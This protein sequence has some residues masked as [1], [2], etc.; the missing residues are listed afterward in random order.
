MIAN[1][2]R[3]WSLLHRAAPWLANKDRTM[4]WSKKAELVAEWRQAFNILAREARVPHLEMAEVIIVHYRSRGR[5]PD[6]GACSPTAKAAIDGIVDAGVLADDDPS[7][8]VKI[9]YK[10]SQM[11]PSWASP[12]VSGAFGMEIREVV[13]F[14]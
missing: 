11:P 4:H 1:T 2:G 10:V 8:L 14:P 12:F 13:E 5:W 3:S 7:H 9:T 6:V